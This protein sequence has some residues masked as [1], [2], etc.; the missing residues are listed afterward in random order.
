MIKVIKNDNDKYTV[1]RFDA[2]GTFEF[3]T[4]GT[5]TKEQMVAI[6]QECNRLCLWI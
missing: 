6:Y 5:Y 2:S 1:K 3:E 4:L